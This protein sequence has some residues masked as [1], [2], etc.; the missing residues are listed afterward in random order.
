MELTQLDVAEYEFRC[1]LWA[2]LGLN[3]H[4]T[5]TKEREILEQQQRERYDISFHSMCMFCDQEFTGN[6]FD[7]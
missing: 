2:S 7:Y 1:R 6:R 3:P 5:A 4:K